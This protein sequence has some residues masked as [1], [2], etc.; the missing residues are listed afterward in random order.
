MNDSKEL[1]LSPKTELLTSHCYVVIF[2][3]VNALMI[4]HYLRALIYSH[5]KNRMIRADS[6]ND[7]NFSAE[8]LILE[9]IVQSMANEGRL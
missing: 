6:V 8:S 5:S 2:L 1:S 7:L 3:T 9:D 4:E